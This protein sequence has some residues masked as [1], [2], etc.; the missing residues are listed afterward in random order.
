MLNA[1]HIR[2]LLVI[3]KTALSTESSFFLSGASYTLEKRTELNGK[4]VMYGESL[5]P[6]CILCPILYFTDV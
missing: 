6:Q 3:T 5:C 4:Y 1:K 2:S